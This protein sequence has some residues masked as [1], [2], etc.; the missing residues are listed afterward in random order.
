MARPSK[1]WLANERNVKSKKLPK[2]VL[3]RVRNNR[4]G[5]YGLSFTVMWRPVGQKHPSQ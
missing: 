2:K 4:N 1:Y 5:Q 3:G